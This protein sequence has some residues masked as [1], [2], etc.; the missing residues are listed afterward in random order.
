MANLSDKILLEEFNKISPERRKQIK[1]D[2][3]NM[4]MKR[5][6]N[7]SLL[8]PVN[9][10]FKNFTDDR[11]GGE[12]DLF[13]VKR[14]HNINYFKNISDDA[15]DFFYNDGEYFE[16]EDANIEAYYR[17][18]NEDDLLSI[19]VFELF[20]PGLYNHPTKRVELDKNGKGIKILRFKSTDEFAIYCTKQGGVYSARDRDCIPIEEIRGRQA[21]VILKDK[22]DDFDSNNST[23][24]DFIESAI[25]EI[26]DPV[27]ISYKFIKKVS[28][29]VKSTAKPIL[30]RVN[31]KF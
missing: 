31:M 17:R 8:F 20:L 13:A 25:N 6:D 11:F 19:G 28:N 10:I 23:S 26:S 12:E 1:D 14:I 7:Y 9:K 3:I 24:F 29:S 2:Y 22:I 30:K 21:L 18:G 27:N 5:D 4:C 16:R 15:I